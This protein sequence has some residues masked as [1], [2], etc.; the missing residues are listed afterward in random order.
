MNEYIGITSNSMED[1]S[2]LFAP[3]R[4]NI[5]VI[6]VTGVTKWLDA[7]DDETK[8]DIKGYFDRIAA[9]KNAIFIFIDKAQEIKSLV[10]ED[11]FKRYVPKD[12]GIYIGKGLGDFT[13][14]SLSNSYKDLNGV[15]PDNFGFNIISGIA[16]KIKVIEVDSNGE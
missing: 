6:V 5:A 1:M 12:K 16:S 11:W 13:Y 15:I 10:Y 7:F 9:L 2:K 4:K 8:K 3:E 14:F